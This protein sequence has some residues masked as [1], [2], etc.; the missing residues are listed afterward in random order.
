MKMEYVPSDKEVLMRQLH[1]ALNLIT[2]YQ[3]IL[4]MLSSH[5]HAY[6]LGNP[7][8]IKIF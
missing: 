6:R 3:K 1:D 4:Y 8:I 2:P 5:F 7:H